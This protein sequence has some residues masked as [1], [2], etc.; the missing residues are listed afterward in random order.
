LEQSPLVGVWSADRL[1][2]P[3]GMSDEWLVFAADGTGY[4]EYANIAPNYALPF[5]WEILSRGRLRLV[6]A[7]EF[8][9]TQG[10][11]PAEFRPVAFDEVFSFEVATEVVRGVELA[12]L[13]L[14]RPI[15]D[16]WGRFS[17]AFGRIAL[18]SGGERWWEVA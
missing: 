5:R 1:D 2:P 10:A 6:A 8:Y 18:V 14:D 15:N 11:L 9:C 12:V 3:G 16:G 4:Q 13:K 7:A 17:S